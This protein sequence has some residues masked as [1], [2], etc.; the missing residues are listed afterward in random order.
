MAENTNDTGSEFE[1]DKETGKK[2]QSQFGQQ[3]QKPEFGQQGQQPPSGQSGQQ[4]EF[5]QQQDG[6][7]GQSG[8]GGTG[9][10]DPSSQ[11][12]FTGQTETSLA[13]RTGAQGGIEGTGGQGSESGSGFVGAQGQESPE[14]LK[15]DKQPSGGQDFAETGQGATDE[16]EE[17][18]ESG[19]TGGSF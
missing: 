8:F 3:G 1:R 14:Y 2:S 5:G 6:E 16:D 18:D 7:S 13:E 10:Q 11:G 15:Q 4:S 17:T 19:K 12:E 9:S